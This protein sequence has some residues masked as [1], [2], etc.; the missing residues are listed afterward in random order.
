MRTKD[1]HYVSS[2]W[3]KRDNKESRNNYCVAVNLLNII[4]IFTFKLIINTNN[5][6]KKSC[7]QVIINEDKELFGE[8]VFY[9]VHKFLDENRMLAYI[10][11]TNKI[12]ND[13]LGVKYFQGKSSKYGFIDISDIDRCV[14]FIKINNRIYIFDKENQVACNQYSKFIQF[15]Y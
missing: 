10:H 11:W 9:L 8:I 4:Y 5:M 1:G 3:I 12:V 14:G 13:Q 6:E 7:F 2:S 15:S